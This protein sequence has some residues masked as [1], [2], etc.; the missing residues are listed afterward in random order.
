MYRIYKY[1]HI[2]QC[3]TQKAKI[4][5]DDEKKDGKPNTKNCLSRLG[6]LNSHIF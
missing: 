3:T 4:T 2:L 1:V 5:S 6:G